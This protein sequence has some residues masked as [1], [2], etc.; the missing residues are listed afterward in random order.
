MNFS[1]PFASENSKATNELEN[2]PIPD[3]SVIVYPKSRFTCSD[4][5]KPIFVPSVRIMLKIMRACVG[6]ENEKDLWYKE[7]S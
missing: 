3:S 6:V 1:D 5:P 2:M 7:K 4:S